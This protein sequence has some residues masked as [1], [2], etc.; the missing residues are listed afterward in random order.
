LRLGIP[1]DK[2]TS[3]NR[4]IPSHPVRIGA[5]RPLPLGGFAQAIDQWL[6]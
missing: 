4:A 1:A 5:A 2:N 3:K 6:F